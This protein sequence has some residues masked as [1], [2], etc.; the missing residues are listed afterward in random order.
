MINSLI[1]NYCK[2]SIMVL[3]IVYD[4]L[5]EMPGQD[6]EN[7]AL[8]ISSPGGSVVFVSLMTMIK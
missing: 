3:H 4:P 5:I 6:A 7:H 2:N 1:S 8:S